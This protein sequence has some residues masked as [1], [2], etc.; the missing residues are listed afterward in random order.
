M[1]VVGVEVMILG[2]G[3]LS[4]RSILI[5]LLLARHSVKKNIGSLKVDS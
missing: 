5:S 3:I 2:E 4:L 1:V